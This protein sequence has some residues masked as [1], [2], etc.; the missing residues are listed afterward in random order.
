MHVRGCGA[1][2]AREHELGKG[3]VARGSIRQAD[4]LK[5]SPLRVALG[6]RMYI[7]RTD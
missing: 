7:K 6:K 5:L 3:W 2:E 4:E 1:R